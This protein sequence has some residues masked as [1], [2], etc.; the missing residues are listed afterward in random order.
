MRE[1]VHKFSLSV[2]TASMGQKHAA[3]QTDTPSPDV[4]DRETRLTSI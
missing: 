2:A 4:S 1:G 3:D